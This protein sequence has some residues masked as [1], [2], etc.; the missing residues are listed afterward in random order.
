LG[1][2]AYFAITPATGYHVADV[3]VDG[4]SVGAV[5]GY[6]F[7]NVIANHAI[8]A[9][10]AI[11]TYTITPSAGAGGSISPSTAWT[12]ASGSS[13][14]FTITPNS[15]YRVATLTVD[16]SQVSGVGSYTFTNVTANHTIS[17][18]FALN[19]GSAASLTIAT[20]AASVT[21]GRQFTL[22]GLMT[23]TPGTVGL[24][25]HVEVKKPGKSYYSYSSNRIVYAGVGGKASWQY[26]YNTLKTQAKGTYMFRVVFD[27]NTSLRPFTSVAKRVTFK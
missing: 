3:L 22:S 19:E 12:L 24:G 16:G 25:V 2:S 23:P 21:R 7:T 17:A 11:N 15:G 6:T 9:T 1:S 27:G 10:F 13:I 4:A 8:S 18:T 14:T 20:S 5:G 26:K